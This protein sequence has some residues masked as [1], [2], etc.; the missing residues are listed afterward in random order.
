MAEI[1]KQ[2]E[3]AVFPEGLEDEKAFWNECNLKIYEELT[4]GTSV[5]N[6]AELN[7]LKIKTIMAI[8]ANP[9]FTKKY[10]GFLL[11]FFNFVEGRRYQL[12]M[13]ALELYW[14]EL[15]DKVKDGHFPTLA[16]EFK[17]LLLGLKEIPLAKKIPK[18][19]Q[20]N[21]G[22]V[23]ISKDEKEDIETSFGIKD[24]EPESGNTQMDKGQ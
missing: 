5:K 19:Q 9:F 18:L 2:K 1:D 8:I 11:N 24:H 6:I 3:V 21:I 10:S 22:E 17:D 7:N 15:K 14:G 12:A 4:K 13:E 20:F 16:K 23:N